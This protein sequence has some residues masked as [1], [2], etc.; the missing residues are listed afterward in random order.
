MGDGKDIVGQVLTYKCIEGHE[1]ITV[2][3]TDQG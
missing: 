2:D 3:S 1:F